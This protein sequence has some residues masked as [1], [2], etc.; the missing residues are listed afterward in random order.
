L[1][2]KRLEGFGEAAGV[3]SHVVLDGVIDD[4][5]VRP[6]GGF[7]CTIIWRIRLPCLVGYAVDQMSAP[8]GLISV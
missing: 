7:R 1:G 8:F 2:G 4:H 3:P 6:R 5:S